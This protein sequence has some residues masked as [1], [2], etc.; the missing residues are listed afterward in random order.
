MCLPLTK[1]ELVCSSAAPQS[2]RGEPTQV[3]P[4]TARHPLGSAQCPEAEG[5]P[6]RLY[7][8]CA[9]QGRAARVSVGRHAGWQSAPHRQEMVRVLFVRLRVPCHGLYWV[10]KV[11]F[12]HCLNTTVPYFMAHAVVHGDTEPNTQKPP[13]G[14]SVDGGKRG[15]GLLKHRQSA[16]DGILVAMGFTIRFY[17][18]LNK[19]PLL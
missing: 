6:S 10:Q 5:H 8:N 4:E 3:F 12:C 15:G 7:E 18:F 2:P 19:N 16:W 1:K 17:L 13:N 9:G 11:G 14:K